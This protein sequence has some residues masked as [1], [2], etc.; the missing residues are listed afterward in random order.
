MGGGGGGGGSEKSVERDAVGKR[1][2]GRGLGKG[3]QED[4]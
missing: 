2:S 1:D 4:A 3:M